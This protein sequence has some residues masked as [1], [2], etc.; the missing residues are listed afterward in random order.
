MDFGICHILPAVAVFYTL[1]FSPL[2]A[3]RR[4]LFSAFLFHDFCM[5]P[6]ASKLANLAILIIQ[7]SREIAEILA[8]FI[9]WIRSDFADIPSRVLYFVFVAFP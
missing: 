4:F 6:G 9:V 8:A 7:L 2:S 1:Y 3:T 5:G